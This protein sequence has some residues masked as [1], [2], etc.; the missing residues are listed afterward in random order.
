[1]K[2]ANSFLQNAL[3]FEQGIEGKFCVII[4]LNNMRLH[5]IFPGQPKLVDRKRVQGIDR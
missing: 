4:H 3:G 1:M 2:D 5:R